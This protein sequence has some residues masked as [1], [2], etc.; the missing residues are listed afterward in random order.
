MSE[1]SEKHDTA[2]T[3]KRKMN[4]IKV[5]DTTATRT[6]L[7]FATAK[8]INGISNRLDLRESWIT[9][10]CISDATGVLS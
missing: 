7:F 5:T 1:L 6:G 9:S 4:I 8:G 3:E 10:F 2:D